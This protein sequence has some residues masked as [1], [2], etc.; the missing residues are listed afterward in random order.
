MAKEV[1]KGLGDNGLPADAKV[2]N[3]MNG[4][5]KVMTTKKKLMKSQNRPS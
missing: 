5:T 3:K 4:G 1:L 2:L